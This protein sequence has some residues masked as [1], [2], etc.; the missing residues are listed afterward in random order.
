MKKITSLF[1]LFYSV[2]ALA[3][4]PQLVIQRGHTAPVTD[5][6]VS[7]KHELVITT[8]YDKT[9][10]VWQKETA[11][12]LRAYTGL[13]KGFLPI[14]LAMSFDKNTVLASS[15]GGA[16]TLIDL[17]KN[18]IQTIAAPLDKG[19]I[20]LQ[21]HPTK[22]QIAIGYE[23]GT[24][25]LFDY[26][27]EKILQSWAVGESE[28]TK[29]QLTSKGRYLFAQSKKGAF[30]AYDLKKE[31]TIGS[32]A[33][34]I[35]AFSVSPDNQKLLTVAQ[36]SVV[37]I[38]KIKKTTLNAAKKINTFCRQTFWT[39]TNEVL[40]INK[41]FQLEKLNAITFESEAVSFPLPRFYCFKIENNHLY[42]NQGPTLKTADITN[43]EPKNIYKGF[44]GNV[45]TSNINAITFQ[46]NGRNIIAGG[47]EKAIQFW[48]ETNYETI[49]VGYE[50]NKLKLNKD[51][52]WLLCSGTG[53]Q[54]HLIDV[55]KRAI[56]QVYKGHSKGLME[57]DFLG[58]DRIVS[59]SKD[60]TLKVW[61]MD[62][63]SIIHDL[64]MHNAYIYAVAT[65]GNKIVSGDSKGLIVAWNATT[66][67]TIYTIQNDKSTVY[68]LTFSEDGKTVF[69]TFDNGDVWSWDDFHKIDFR[70]NFSE[71]VTPSFKMLGENIVT[72]QKNKTLTNGLISIQS[73]FFKNKKEENKGFFIEN[74]SG[75]NDFQWSD[76]QQFLV[77][78]DGDNAIR[79]YNFKNNKLLA[80]CYTLGNKNWAIVTPD[81]LFDASAN[82]MNW[83]HY[84][85]FNEALPL[86][87]LKERYYE[88]DL[89]QKLLGYNEEPLRNP[90][91]FG[92][93]ELFPKTKW[94]LSDNFIANLEL[95]P[96]N[97]GIGKVSIFINKK[98]IIADANPERLTN[99]EINLN[100]YRKYLLNDTTNQIS[101]Q[102]YNE[103]GWLH[104]GFLTKNYTNTVN[105]RG[106]NTATNQ[107]LRLKKRHKPTF[108]ALI[109]GT[110]DYRGE[111]LDLSFADKDAADIA[112]A[113]ELA[114]QSLFGAA[115][116]K[117]ELLNTSQSK[118]K[119]PSKENIKAAF[120]VIAQEAKAEDVFVLYLSGHGVNYGSPNSQ[121]YYLTKSIASEELGDDNIRTNYTISS[122][123][124]TAQLK[125]IAAQKQIM[126]LDACSS[127]SLVQN[128]LS[129]S[130]SL[131]SSQ[132][133][134]L[135]RMKD[136]AGVFILAGSAANKVSYEASQFGQGLLTYSL[137]SGIRGGALREN[138]FVDV[139]Q[140]FQYAADKVPELAAVIGGVQRPVV[141][142]PTGTNSFDIG[143]ITDSVRYKI[144]LEE[145]KPLF[146]KS[147]FQH[148]KDYEDLIDL[149]DALDETFK[150]I[151][152][153][154][155]ASI[156]FLNVK[157]YPKAYS[158]KGRYHKNSDG[159]LVLK[160]KLLKDKKAIGDFEITENTE[161]EL[162]DGVL[163]AVMELI[164]E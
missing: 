158:I 159:M 10:K 58:D 144:P 69:A 137:L 24:L 71:T 136:R 96:R 16:I 140:L 114:G 124:F 76:D 122:E 44:V 78:A 106:A 53:K 5:V 131:S 108:Y 118:E 110:S 157:K 161:T 86:D 57:V 37:S 150:T 134:A 1:F 113:L 54:F 149:S 63:T 7:Q 101:L 152:D 40:L 9:V 89:L 156:L 90:A 148:E 164:N 84:A 51:G 119:Q 154:S 85:H 11:R 88:P 143:Q 66:G 129:Q 132:K 163:E 25:I 6:V 65:D 42:Y 39:V 68:D 116:T 83:L 93:V 30:L 13:M 8:S 123:E 2:F 60:K 111:A 4:T 95:L 77:S 121:F 21:A 139:M 117:V 107:P 153:D 12:E 130:R 59:V 103:K 23:D 56:Q 33:Q 80:T 135:D 35:V 146:I 162:I 145:V 15:T 17:S 147:N 38:F 22:E 99:L 18:V 87:Q 26:K 61:S 67:D 94:T 47:G 72:L 102:V 20:K 82:G 155:D 75:I 14:Q 125:N 141:A 73:D 105:A 115:N 32:F 100:P 64:K 27:N 126:M 112:N 46:K 29:I 98:E 109:I 120:E 160:A 104:S 70:K 92:S 36:D 34:N 62:S 91:A 79:L 74:E 151:S 127:G 19:I 31:K 133:R 81:G 55:E 28:I 50:I 52:K 43:F 128:M 45:Y 97:G 49:P 142:T 41:K 138:E 48:G 3:Q